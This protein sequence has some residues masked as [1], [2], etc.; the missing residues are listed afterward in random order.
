MPGAIRHR[1]WWIVPAVLALAASLL[2]GPASPAA[3]VD[4]VADHPADYSACVGPATESAGFLD[5]KGS[6]AE[7]A[8]NCLAYYGITKGNL[9]R[10]VLP[11][12]CDTALAD[13]SVPGAG[14]RSR[15]DRGS[16]GFRSGVHRPRPAGTRHPGRHQPVG[17]AAH[18]AG[19]FGHHLLAVR[20]CDPPADGVAADPLP[21]GCAGR[22]RRGRHR[23][24]RIRRRPLPGSLLGERHHLPGDPASSTSR[25]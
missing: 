4:G 7:A 17:R 20:G 24:D 19:H 21:R 8:A 1:V 2:I 3:A 15:R 22:S 14:D 5:M 25:G 6:F 23:Q 13:G 18:H 12:R 9:G 11:Q 16:Q 10:D